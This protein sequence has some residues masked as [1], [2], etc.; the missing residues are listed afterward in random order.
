[1][2]GCRDVGS[3]VKKKP[4]DGG[5]RPAGRARTGTGTTTTTTTTEVSSGSVGFWLLNSS[6][7]LV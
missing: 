6:L 1:V 7:G 3:T 4:R 2:S 5:R